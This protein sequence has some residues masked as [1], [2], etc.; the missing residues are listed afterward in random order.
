MNN[1][2]VTL[3]NQIKNDK[4]SKL[5]VFFG[6]ED[7][8]TELYT[9][10]ICEKIP[11]MG[12]PEF[13]RITLDGKD[14]APVEIADAVD[15]FPMMAER[16]AVIISESGAFG[17]KVSAEIKELYLRIF[18]NLS[19]DTVIIIKETNV[20]KRGAVYKSAKKH[21]TVIEFKRLS[22]ADIVTWIMREARGLGK[23]VSKQNAI[24]MTSI[25]GK[26]LNALKNEIEKLSS[27]AD[28]DEITETDIRRLAS[29]SLE[30]RVF[31]LCDYMMNK[32]A[33]SALLL[34]EDLKTNK[35]SPFAI[36]YLFY[37]EFEKLLKAKLYTKQN[38]PR[39]DIASA[40][41]VPPFKVAKYISA[42]R[43]FSED[44]LA[45]LIIMVP[46][47]DLSVKRGEIQEWQ[48]IE[49]LVFEG[50]GGKKSDE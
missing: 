45:H 23:T 14:S 10:R 22:D 37:I 16:K 2:I 13:N 25:C 47:L 1:D 7:F 9:K 8:L 36:L 28:G 42:A 39:S 4:L 32:N 20:D 33:D 29:R 31:D 41:S 46:Q 6:E 11:D 18:E 17:A 19:D 3:K 34:M 26:N 38:M 35:E 49:A 21:G 12:F 44:E 15:T 27:Y 24:L 50:I 40:I 30:A 43:S 48:A 5:Y